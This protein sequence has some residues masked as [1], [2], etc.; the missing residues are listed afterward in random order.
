MDHSK[1]RGEV[2]QLIRDVGGGN[3]PALLAR[4]PRAF[5]R[6]TVLCKP[7]VNDCLQRAVDR[8]ESR[9]AIAA[10]A[11]A[12]PEETGGAVLT[13]YVSAD[14]SASTHRFGQ[15]PQQGASQAREQQARH[16][17]SG[18]ATDPR[19]AQGGSTRRAPRA[20]SAP[21]S[22]RSGASPSP[23][24]RRGAVMS[25]RSHARL[26]LGSG[27]PCGAVDSPGPIYQQRGYG[28]DNASGRSFARARRDI[29]LPDKGESAGPSFPGLAAIGPQLTSTRENPINVVFSRADRFG[30]AKEAERAGAAAAGLGTLGGPAK[31]PFRVPG[32]NA[33]FNDIL[34]LPHHRGGSGTAPAPTLGTRHS[35]REFI[36]RLHFAD[37][38][39]RASP[40]PIYDVEGKQRGVFETG[41]R[42]PSFG[43]GERTPLERL[44]RV[45]GPGTYSPSTAATAVQGPMVR[46]AR[47]RHRAESR[48]GLDSP[49]P[50]YE[51][52]FEHAA[53]HA[54]G[55][56]IGAGPEEDADKDR[57]GAR[58]FMGKKLSADTVGRDSPG[59]A[60]NPSVA[61]EGP[62]H[63]MTFKEPQV[64][65]S[66]FPRPLRARWISKDCARD[67]LGAWSPGPKYDTRGDIARQGIAFS[68]GGAGTALSA[69]ATAAGAR[70]RHDGSGTSAGA[71]QHSFGVSVSATLEGDSRAKS[72]LRPDE[73]GGGSPRDA[74][75][76]TQPL[77]DVTLL[78]TK[79][80]P[81]SVVISSITKR[82][83]PGRGNAADG[84]GAESSSA[85]AAADRSKGAAS[86]DR[87]VSPPRL[88]EPRYALTEVSAPSFTFGRGDRSSAIWRST[89]DR[90]DEASRAGAAALAMAS[91][92]A[93]FVRVSGPRLGGLARM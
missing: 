18:G 74:S 12:T 20:H 38:Q 83:L 48:A 14:G 47:A 31:G 26:Y 25:F 50:V 93:P 85:A 76:A 16:A 44:E 28:I 87:S 65:Q 30:D 68:F 24:S 1:L 53:K 92:T 29:L 69:T 43:K 59:P 9:L 64:R 15:H 56:R 61:W 32:A 35:D 54:R 62:R 27:F 22:G 91:V 7:P 17:G 3:D 21:R 23:S 73:R 10:A 2:E 89:V 40:G 37:L 70:G 13:P 5:K 75:S 19:N 8:V 45:P 36:S 34:R 78:S 88:I 71:A 55:V 80:Q 63:T 4:H 33:Y 82:K 77:P 58:L 11:G 41:T 42:A 81:R 39:G 52:A 60:Y 86:G 49:G 79:M 72:A 57:F 66:L 67:N 6:G 46:F 84:S 51:P 90:G